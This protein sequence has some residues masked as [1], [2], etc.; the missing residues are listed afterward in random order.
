MR[1]LPHQWQFSLQERAGKL[2][3]PPILAG[4]RLICFTDTDIFALDI[5]TGEEVKAEDGFPRTLGISED[6]PLPAHSRGTFYYYVE[7]W[8]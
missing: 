5:Y 8:R 6:P 7:D 1:I 3:R 4:D 2:E